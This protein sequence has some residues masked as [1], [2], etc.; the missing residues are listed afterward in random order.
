PEQRYALHKDIYEDI[1]LLA[2]AGA[3]RS[4]T[5]PVPTGFL[6]FSADIDTL[7][8]TSEAIEAK[9]RLLSLEARGHRPPRKGEELGTNFGDIL[10]DIGEQVSQANSID[11]QRRAKLTEIN[12]AREAKE[13]EKLITL[14]FTPGTFLARPFFKNQ[15]RTGW[16]AALKSGNDK[17]Q[18]IN[19]PHL[20]MRV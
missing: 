20:K 10:P 9:N 4:V 6:F 16:V 18:E 12:K 17:F 3:I 2:T 5:V 13:G 19:D 14:E 7:G 8:L 1:M 15:G 11:D